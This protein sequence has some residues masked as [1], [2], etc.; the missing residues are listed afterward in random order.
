MLSNYFRNKK[1]SKKGFTLVE[2]ICSIIILA[3]VFAGVL[4]SVAFARQMVFTNNIRDK[5][6]DRGQL[7][8][9]EMITV[10]TGYDPDVNPSDTINNAIVPQ[11]KEIINND[12]DPQVG[13]IGKVEHVASFTDL[14]SYD[15]SKPEIEFTIEPVTEAYADGTDTYGN[16]F[17]SAQEKGWNIT[18]RIYYK[19]INGNRSW[20]ATEISAFA[21]YNYI[22]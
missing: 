2:A 10:C 18:I 20:Q 14:S 13:S 7:I 19:S 12:D 9:D 17:K 8:A 1:T 4:N 3:M 5:A 11:I 6:S 21:P 15:S 22:K 16:D